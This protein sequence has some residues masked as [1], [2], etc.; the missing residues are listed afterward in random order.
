MVVEIAVI[1]F[2]CIMLGLVVYTARR[3]LGLTEAEKHRW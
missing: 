1:I 2:L 3:L